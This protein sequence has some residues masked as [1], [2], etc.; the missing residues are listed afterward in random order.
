[1][2]CSLPFLP[3]PFPFPPYQTV[4]AFVSPLVGNAAW[5]RV[6]SASLGAFGGLELWQLWICK[7]V[8]WSESTELL[9]ALEVVPGRCSEALLGSAPFAPWRF[10]CQ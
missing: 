5:G 6:L 4:S 1:M 7:L 3:F 10:A 2:F 8:Q 9:S